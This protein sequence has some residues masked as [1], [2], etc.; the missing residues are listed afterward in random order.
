MFIRISASALTVRHAAHITL[1][2]LSGIPNG[3]PRQ[4]LSTGVEPLAGVLDGYIADVLLV[5]SVRCK[6]PAAQDSPLGS[7]QPLHVQPLRLGSDG[8]SFDGGDVFLSS[9]VAARPR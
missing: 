9:Y 3:S 7:R 4:T 8:L 1:T 2:F 5:G 6:P